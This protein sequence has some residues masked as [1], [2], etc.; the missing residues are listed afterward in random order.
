MS[1]HHRN[2][3][4]SCQLN[5]NLKPGYYRFTHRGWGLIEHWEIPFPLRCVKILMMCQMINMSCSL[6]TLFFISNFDNIVWTIIVNLKSG[7][8][9]L[10]DKSIISSMVRIQYCFTLWS[11]YSITLLIYFRCVH[12]HL[13]VFT[14]YNSTIF[15]FNQSQRCALIAR[16]VF[17]VLGGAFSLTRDNELRNTFVKYLVFI[18]IRYCI[19]HILHWLTVMVYNTLMWMSCTWS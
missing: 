7:T 3:C 15:F 8:L 19:I 17:Y 6:Y 9:P 18:T 11:E 14:S 12:I 16:D 5:N 2:V 4:F 13:I 10:V 1:A